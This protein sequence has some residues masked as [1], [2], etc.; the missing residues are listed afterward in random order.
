MIVVSPTELRANQKKYLDL[1]GV[2]QVFIKRGDQLIELV[3]R[4]PKKVMS[5]K[6]FTSFDELKSS[7]SEIVDSL[8]SLKK[9]VGFE[10]AIMEIKSVGKV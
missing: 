7:E 6:K 10:K 1:A 3:V 4:R 2:E 9:H 5:V 8:S